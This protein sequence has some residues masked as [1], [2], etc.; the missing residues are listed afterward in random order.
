MKTLQ[1]NFTT[2]EQSKR[3]LE[4][5][6]PADSADMVYM[7]INSNSKVLRGQPIVLPDWALFKDYNL[8]N[9]NLIN[10]ILGL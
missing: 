5:G 4:L 1:N 6:V 2:P 9:G 3:M 10:H 8:G 7:T